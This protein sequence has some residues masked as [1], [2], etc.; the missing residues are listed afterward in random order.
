LFFGFVLLKN[1]KSQLKLNPK[2]AVPFFSF[3]QVIGKEKDPSEYKK[4]IV[5]LSALIHYS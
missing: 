2:V 5:G 4:L 1:K 3:S